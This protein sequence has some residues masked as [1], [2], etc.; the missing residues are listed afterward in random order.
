MNVDL[1]GMNIDFTTLKRQVEKIKKDVCLIQRLLKNK[2]GGVC[3]FFNMYK[4]G[5][6]CNNVWR[7]IRE[8]C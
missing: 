2:D 3:V 6:V 4:D 1:E 7:V 8:L 5:G